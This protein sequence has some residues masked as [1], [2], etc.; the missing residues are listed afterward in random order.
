MPHNS[1]IFFANLPTDRVSGVRP[2][3]REDRLQKLDASD[4]ICGIELEVSGLG[5]QLRLITAD[6]LIRL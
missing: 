2:R 6:T 1:Q 4:K 5:N 3:T